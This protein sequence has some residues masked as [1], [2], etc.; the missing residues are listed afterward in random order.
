[1]SLDKLA[2]YQ[3][4]RIVKAGRI[5]GVDV[6]RHRLCVELADGRDHSFSPVADFFGRSVP[7]TGHYFL[8][9]DDGYQSHSPTAV[10]ENG[11]T[12]LSG[13]LPKR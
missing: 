7:Q 5:L 13:S 12:R 8:L 1:M 6:E 11:Y 4:R 10:F 3:S 9:Y 2:N